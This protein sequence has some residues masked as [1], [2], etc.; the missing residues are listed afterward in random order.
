M[1]TLHYL[2]AKTMEVGKEKEEEEEVDLAIRVASLLAL[3]MAHG[4]TVW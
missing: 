4:G 1:E 3:T 2:I